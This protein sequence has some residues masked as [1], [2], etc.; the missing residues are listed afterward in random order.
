[1]RH[2]DLSNEHPSRPIGHVGEELIGLTTIG[3]FREIVALG[4]HL[5]RCQ[6]SPTRS[7]RPG[8]PS[9][10]S[11]L[12]TPTFLT[13]RPGRRSLAVNVL[14]PL[15]AAMPRPFTCQRRSWMELDGVPVAGSWNV[16]V[17]AALPSGMISRVKYQAVMMSAEELP[18]TLTNIDPDV[19]PEFIASGVP[20]ARG[21]WCPA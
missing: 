8:N 15:V 14:P 4:L 1:M 13:R 3:P 17:P 11:C 19:V 12:P 6:T 20:D 9:V 21:C 18:L 5:H 2:G 16:S 10:A 7:T